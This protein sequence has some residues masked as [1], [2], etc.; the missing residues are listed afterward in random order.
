MLFA[1]VI[2]LGLVLGSRFYPTV[3]YVVVSG[4]KHYSATE[5]AKLAN[6]AVGTPF[7]WITQQRIRALADDPWLQNVQIIREFPDAIHIRVVERVPVLTDGMQSYAIDGTVLPDVNAEARESLVNLS[8]WG[9][10][11]VAEA[12]QLWQLL[13]AQ[14]LE[15]ISYSP[16][17]F[18]LQ[19]EST[20]QGTADVFTPSVE[21]LKTQWASVMA[22]KGKRL[23]LYSW[24][25]TAHE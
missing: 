12:L 9:E 8:G 20:E 2:L 10:S 17:G 14:G 24:G 18:T 13:H 19:F 16:A 11:R 25:V 4:N 15:V 6:I 22:L 3:D 7:F 5:I 1:L 21:A 23:A